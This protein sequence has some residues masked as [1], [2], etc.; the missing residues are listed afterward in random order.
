MTVPSHLAIIMD[1]NG[2]WA[3]K[4]DLARREGHKQGVDVLKDVIKESQTLGISCLTV[5]AF[6]TENWKRPRLEVKFL[7]KLFQQTLR[8]EAQELNENEVQVHIIGRRKGLP[9]YLLNEI[10]YIENLTENNSGLQLN[11]AFNYGGRAE[12]VDTFKKVIKENDSTD[13]KI[14]DINEEKIHNHLY[15]SDYPEVEL[16]IRTGGELRLSNFLLWEI[17]YAE[18]YFTDKFWPEFKRK[19]LRKA[20]KDFQRRDRRFGTIE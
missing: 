1:G 2:R 13:F 17:A 6:S 16:L 15:N 18:L 12:L 9:E 5:Y 3:E 19:D 4:N 14:D 11:I 7:M 20:V 10:D 8:S